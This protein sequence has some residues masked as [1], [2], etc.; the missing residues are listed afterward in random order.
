MKHRFGKTLT[1]VLFL[2][3]LSFLIPVLSV[4]SLAADQGDIEK[5]VRA[6]IEIGSWMREYMKGIRYEEQTMEDLG[7]ME[8]EINAKVGEILG[9]HGLTRENYEKKSAEVLA[10]KEGLQAFFEAHPEIKK[11][12]DKLPMHGMRGGPPPSATPPGHP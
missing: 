11:E 2:L 4:P 12:Y 8:Q 7:K 6:R 1:I 5:I 10:D 3:V 9:S